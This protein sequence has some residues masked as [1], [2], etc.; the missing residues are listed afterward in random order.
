MHHEA[1][2]GAKSD[3]RLQYLL[4]LHRSLEYAAYSPPSSS[5]PAPSALSSL[6][7]PC[8]ELWG[9]DEARPSF[10][11]PVWSRRGFGEARPLFEIRALPLDVWGELDEEKTWSEGELN[12]EKAWSQACELE[13]EEQLFHRAP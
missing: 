1:A 13:L 10:E 11:G 5:A 9:F 12:E 7:G 6:F 8:L 2:C 4:A 3:L